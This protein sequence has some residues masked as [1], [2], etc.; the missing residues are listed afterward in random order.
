MD[1]IYQIDEMV[2]SEDLIQKLCVLCPNPEEEGLL[3]EN[4]DR[5]SK[6]TPQEQFLFSLIEIPQ[7]KTRLEMIQFRMQFDQ[8]YLAY[9]ANLN[10]LAKGIASIKDSYELKQVFVIILKMGNFLN[11]QDKLKG[12]KA[13]FKPELLCSL[14]MTKGV[15]AFKGT[16]MMDFLL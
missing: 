2:L 14:A 1:A 12:N 8:K 13:N 11:Q 7:L 6:L 16:T 3:R 4:A 9:D 10:Y 15:G 5:I